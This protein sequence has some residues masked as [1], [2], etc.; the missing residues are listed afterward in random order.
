[1]AEKLMTG[2]CP[3]GTGRIGSFFC[4]QWLAVCWLSAV[5]LAPGFSAPARARDPSAARNFKPRVSCVEDQGGVLVAAEVPG[6]AGLRCDIWCYEDQLGQPVSRKTDG[7]SVV[8]TH[9]LNEATV[10]SRFVPVD[11]GL[12]ILVEVSGPK[13][14][15]VKAVA[16]LN[17]CC[18]FRRSEA[19]KNQGDY[20]KD[21]VARC[22]VILDDGMRMLKDTRRVPGTRKGKD[23]KANLPEPWIQEYDPSWRKHPGQVRGERGRSLDRPVYPLI[24][25]VSRD[26]KYLAAIAWPETRSLG[27]VWHDCLHPRPAIAESFDGRTGRIMSRGRLYFLPNDEAALLSAF[28]RDFP[29]W[30]RPDRKIGDRLCYGSADPRRAAHGGSGGRRHG[31]GPAPPS[32]L[33]GLLRPLSAVIMP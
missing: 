5:V 4:F 3:S 14:A 24:G 19:F 21:F 25:C 33:A 27:Q 13:L 6:A 17:P 1:M 11:D 8:L 16:S 9:R 30:K 15:A 20:V 29:D 2:K 31:P 22:F 32:R 7:E 12:E 26:G 23:D 10:V 18:Q 28:R